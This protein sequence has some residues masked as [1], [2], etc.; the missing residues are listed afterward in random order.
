[1]DM[2]LSQFSRMALM[3]LSMPSDMFAKAAKMLGRSIPEGQA[4]G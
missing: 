1:M 2:D 3:R 4:E